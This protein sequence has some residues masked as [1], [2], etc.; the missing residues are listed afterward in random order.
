MAFKPPSTVP[1]TM[2]VSFPA[3]PFTVVQ[4]ELNTVIV[5]HKIMVKVYAI[6]IYIRVCVRACVCINAKN[7]KW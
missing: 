5:T 7:I 6:G 1:S 3:L 2:D 4:E